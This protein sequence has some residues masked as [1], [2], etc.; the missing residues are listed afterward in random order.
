MEIIDAYCGIG[1]WQKRDRLLPWRPEETLGLMDHF[2][3]TRALVAAAHFDFAGA[4]RANPLVVVV[5]PLLAAVALRFA[6]RVLRDWRA[7]RR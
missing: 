6:L 4:W 3:I 1:P 5:L 7:E 2:G